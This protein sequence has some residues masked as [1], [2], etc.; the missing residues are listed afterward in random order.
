MKK[1]TRKNGFTLIE[2]M[3]AVSIF[4]LVMTIS[5]GSI[6]SIFDANRKSRSLK[7]V[8]TNLNLAVESMSRELRFGKNYHCGSSGVQTSPQNCASGDTSLSFLSSDNEQ[9]TYRFNNNS[10]EK[11][12]GSEEY[13]RV[14][15]PE[16]VIDNLTFYTQGA[17]GGDTVQPKILV[18]LQSHAGVSGKGGSSFTLQTLVSQRSLD[19]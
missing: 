10:L 6:L 2:M 13:I 1:N 3:T 15:A 9:V 12:V 7:T 11:K 5:M 4:V 14:T 8:L 19:F 16:I 17:G 18:K